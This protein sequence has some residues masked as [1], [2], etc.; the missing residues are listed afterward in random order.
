M[1]KE[2]LIEKLKNDYK[3]LTSM[4]IY[5]GDGEKSVVLE[6]CRYRSNKNCAT[7]PQVRY[8]EGFDNV[9]YQSTSNLLKANKW[10]MS[11]CITIAK[12]NSDFNFR[13]IL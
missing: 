9:D 7:M 6:G 10:F 11:A 4:S 3:K 8:L 12:E 13:V 5:S 2:V 1:K